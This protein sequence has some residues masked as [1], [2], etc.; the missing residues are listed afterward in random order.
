MKSGNYFFFY[1]LFI[2]SFNACQQVSV[3]YPQKNGGK[4]IRTSIDSIPI[5]RIIY[6]NG[7]DKLRLGDSMKETLRIF[8]GFNIKY[9]EGY[10]Y[11]VSSLDDHHLLIFSS[12]DEETV[13]S[14]S[15]FS[16]IF[17]TENG[18]SVGDSLHKVKAVY[19]NFFLSQGHIEGP[20][21][22]YSP[23]ELEVFD[24]DGN[25]LHWTSFYFEPFNTHLEFIGDY[26]NPIEIEETY[27]STKT[28]ITP[29][30]VFEIRITKW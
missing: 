16:S 11:R 8:D 17:S 7:V 22:F 12:K 26:K 5:G 1:L 18:I 19:P 2:L 10:G 21:E 24:E 27:L 4:K 3:Y 30:Y 20:S 15:F 23:K 6:G 25:L 13:G 14:I 9:F 29:G 28:F